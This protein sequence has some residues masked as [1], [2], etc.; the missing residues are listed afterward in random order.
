MSVKRSAHWCFSIVDEDADSVQQTEDS[1]EKVFL[2]SKEF[3]VCIGPEEIANS[4]AA[5]KY[6]PCSLHVSGG[7]SR[8]YGQ[9]KTMIQEYLPNLINGI[10]D[11]KNKSSAAD[12]PSLDCEKSV[13][14]KTSTAAEEMLNSSLDKIKNTGMVVTAQRFK[15]QIIHDAGLSFYQKNKS[16]VNTMLSEKYLFQPGRKVPFTCNPTDNFMNMFKAVALFE[17]QIRRNLTK[18]SYVT[19][20]KIAS[21][22]DVNEMT[23]LIVF[24]ALLP[25]VLDRWEGVDG[26]PSLYLYGV[27]NTGK[28]YM[29]TACPYYRKIA[30]D[31]LGVGRFVLQGIES[32]WLM[33]DINVSWIDN[34]TNTSVLR[35]ITIGGEHTVK[36][37]GGTSNVRG[38]VVVTSNDKPNFLGN[39][40]QKYSGD[41]ELNCAA[42]KRRFISV[43]MTE[44]L[45]IDPLTIKW[46]HTST[47]NAALLFLKTL[48]LRFRTLELQNA[49]KMYKDHLE[50]MQVLEDC[51]E[52]DQHYAAI[53]KWIQ[54]VCPLPSLTN[55]NNSSDNNTQCEICPV[56]QEHYCL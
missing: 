41:W 17:R 30:S 15:Q 19:A 45:D 40:P 47:S 29:F 42:W 11:L 18:N 9:A 36:N 5:K 26:L 43:K 27:P 12:D 22:L 6:R 49:I 44:T 28:S 34:A 8:T 56:Q 53:E 38:F 10:F 13:F 4:E 46:D 1:G 21:K 37:K 24:L 23:N 7:H 52:F 48:V 51:T 2:N 50:A 33:D 35:D 14:P 39:A 25:I 31:A 3:R 32:S 16:M 55:F 54:T 20:H